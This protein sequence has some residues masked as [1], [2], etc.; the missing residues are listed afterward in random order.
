[1]GVGSQRRQ[2]TDGD[3]AQ[4]WKRLRRDF[5]AA[6]LLGNIG[7]AQLIENSTDDIRRLVDSIDALG[8][9]VHLNSLQEVLQPEGTPRFRGD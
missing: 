3:A 5:P 9:F 4:E 7:L 2:L 1:M 8:L 6:L